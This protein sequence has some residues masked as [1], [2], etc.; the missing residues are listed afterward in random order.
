MIITA[1]INNAKGSN[2]SAA[3]SFQTSNALAVLS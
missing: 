1:D 3:P 2:D